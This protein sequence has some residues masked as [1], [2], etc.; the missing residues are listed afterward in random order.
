MSFLKKI[1]ISLALIIFPAVSL[2]PASVQAG[3][4][5]GSKGE[6]CNGAQ[7]GASG[8]CGGAP[9]SSLSNRIKNIVNILSAIVGVA[10]V[11]MVIIGGF[12]YITASGDSNSINSAK[13]TIIY[14]VIGAV[15]A[16]LA[17]VIVRFVLSRF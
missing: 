10:A 11:I 1:T 4:F 3:P 7:L 13:N 8:G 17:Q 2:A 6:A 12:R 5:D 9:G 14:A 15:I 16:T